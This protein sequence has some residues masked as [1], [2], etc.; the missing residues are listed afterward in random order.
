MNNQAIDEQ[1][2]CGQAQQLAEWKARQQQA[3]GKITYITPATDTRDEIAMARLEKV[4]AVI[5]LITGIVIIVNAVIC[6]IFQIGRAAGK[7]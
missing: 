2:A 4:M 5:G 3:Q 1:Y 7:W 6:I